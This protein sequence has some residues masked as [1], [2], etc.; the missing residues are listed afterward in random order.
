MGTISG[1]A[2]NADPELGP[3][4]V[5]VADMTSVLLSRRVDVS[6]YGCIYASSGKNLGPA[7][8]AL[9]IVRRDLLEY[10]ADHIPSIMSWKVAH[11]CANIYNTP[12]V[13]GIWAMNAVL[14]NYLRNGGMDNI[15]AECER[16]TSMLYDVIDS[17]NGFYVNN[18]PKEH[19]SLTAIPFF[20]LDGNADIEKQ[21]IEEAADNGI[22]QI[23]GHASVGG[24]RAAVY[25]ALPTSSVQALCRFMADF[26]TRTDS[27]APEVRSERQ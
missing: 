25:N 14:E 4:Q 12:N 8:I 18:V 1:I 24:L 6:K 7:G 13:F 20:I 5:L 3:D 2:L 10:G 21:F 19:R 23:F 27:S 22:V 16:K 26:Q 11:Q 15:V 9:I 17:S